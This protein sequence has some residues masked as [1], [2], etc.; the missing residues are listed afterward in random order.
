MD[1]LGNPDR[2]L[3]NFLPFDQVRGFP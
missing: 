2:T 3:Y 1:Q